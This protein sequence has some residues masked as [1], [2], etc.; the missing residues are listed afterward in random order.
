MHGK[1]L[2][3]LKDHCPGGPE[4]KDHNITM[5]KILYYFN[6]IDQVGNTFLLFP[7]DRITSLECL[8]PLTKTLLIY[9]FAPVIPMFFFH[10]QLLMSIKSCIPLLLCVNKQTASWNKS[11]FCHVWECWALFLFFMWVA[12][13]ERK[14]NGWCWG[15][16]LPEFCPV[17]NGPI[18]QSTA[19]S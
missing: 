1:T 2:I 9:G 10:I 14:L 15:F 11:Q 13:S 4:C 3:V 8:W 12:K 7:A 6:D 19:I 5:P 18:A 16:L 17:I